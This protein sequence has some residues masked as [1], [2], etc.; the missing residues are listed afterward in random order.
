MGTNAF[1][2]SSKVSW[3]LGM[4]V[5]LYRSGTGTT[6]CWAGIGGAQNHSLYL[7][8]FPK[9]NSSWLQLPLEW[10]QVHGTPNVFWSHQTCTA[11]PFTIESQC[12]VKL[13]LSTSISQQIL[14]NITAEDLMQGGLTDM[15]LDSAHRL[16]TVCNQS[17]TWCIH[18]KWQALFWMA[19]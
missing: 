12:T 9:I 16:L 1:Y 19:G 4:C 15:V 5:K 3:A 18:K 7:F 17:T 13:G 11:C 2:Y 8:L 6:A 10:E 14:S